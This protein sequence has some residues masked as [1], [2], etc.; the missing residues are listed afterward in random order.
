MSQ[1]QTV[2]R[3]R[4]FVVSGPSGVGKDTV[5]AQL[6]QSA[7]C[8]DRLVRCIT[9]TTRMPRPGESD[10]TDYFFLSRSA[11]EKGIAEGSFLEYAEYNGHLYGTPAAEAERHQAAGCDVLLKIEV[12]GGQQIRQRVPD[13][14]L[15]FVNAPSWVELERRL[16]SRETDNEAEMAAR[17]AIAKSEVEA[18]LQYDYCVVNDEPARAARDIGAIILAERCRIHTPCRN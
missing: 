5:L 10:G 7:E 8:P 1:K 15:V 17:L 3:G 12:Q 13:S 16:R 6:L 4:L 2:K 11:F 14:I 9:A 18:G